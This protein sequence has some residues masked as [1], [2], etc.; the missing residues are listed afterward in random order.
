MDRGPGRG[1]R[2]P[3]STRGEPVRVGHRGRHPSASL[4]TAPLLIPRTRSTCGAH[5]PGSGS[6]NSSASTSSQ[7]PW[8]RHTARDSEDSSVG[9]ISRSSFVRSAWRGSFSPAMARSLSRS[10]RS[11]RLPRRPVPRGRREPGRG[12]SRGLRSA[13]A[14]AASRGRWGR[15]PGIRR[16]T[17]PAATGTI[18][19]PNRVTTPPP[20]YQ[21]TEFAR[22]PL[23]VAQQ[24]RPG[25]GSAREVGEH[26][27][28]L[29]AI[30]APG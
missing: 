4:L 15:S 8:R 7:R 2:Q 1:V 29:A 9:K 10:G 30:R 22:Q 16:R 26:R 20:G 23:A 3:G 19:P 17:M 27:I 11:A 14:A 12:A 25:I 6:S 21:H 18:H 13:G 24:V 5:Q 28:T